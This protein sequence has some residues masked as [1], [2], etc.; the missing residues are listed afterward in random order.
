M[1][2]IVSIILSLFLVSNMATTAQQLNGNFTPFAKN[3]L[4]NNVVIN[5]ATY[6]NS[7]YI[8]LG[9]YYEAGK[10]TVTVNGNPQPAPN[11]VPLL[12]QLNPWG[13]LRSDFG[14]G[15]YALF[16]SPTSD[17]G[18]CTIDKSYIANAS[19]NPASIQYILAGHDE[20]GNGYMMKTFLSGAR[21]TAYNG[22]AIRFFNESGIFSRHRFIED[23]VYGQYTVRK[24]GTSFKSKDHII[25]LFHQ[26]RCSYIFLWRQ[27]RY[28]I[29]CA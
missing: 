20:Y 24:A 11:K 22:G 16:T 14:S 3:V 1:R 2:Y 6:E 26:Q 12:M 7:G 23:W 18:S 15:G 9:G 19:S 4:W 10:K 21:P 27:W 28:R 13:T 17:L 8:T 5:T 25:C 29:A